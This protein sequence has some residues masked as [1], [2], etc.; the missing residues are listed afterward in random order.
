MAK[1]STEGG[2][3][4]RVRVSTALLLISVLAVAQGPSRWALRL[5]GIGPVT[6][7][8]TLPQLNTALRE[9]FSA[10]DDD[11]ACFYVEPKSHP[12]VSF[13]MEDGKLVRVD[14]NKVGVATSRGI[15]IGDTE[16]RVKDAYGAKLAVEPSQYSGDVGGHY[17]T[18]R[19]PDQRYGVRFET[20]KGKVTTFYAGKYEAV[21]YVE[22]CL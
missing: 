4:T 2:G 11:S 19:S 16:A 3:V 14:V 18:F 13:M 1:G 5:D 22:G 17:L 7:G 6:I 21:Q 12:Q 15:R 9:H 10:P 8:M 20:E